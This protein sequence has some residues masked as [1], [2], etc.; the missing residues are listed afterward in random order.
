MKRTVITILA[1]SLAALTL[2]VTAAH[3]EE[4][5]QRGPEVQQQRDDRDNRQD[6]WRHDR[7]QARGEARH[8]HDRDD[9]YGQAR[10]DD[11]YRASRYDHDNDRNARIDVDDGDRGVIIDIGGFFAQR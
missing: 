3:A 7:P 2:G 5:D 4:R 8:Q 1:G 10:D 9:R 11:R 6:A